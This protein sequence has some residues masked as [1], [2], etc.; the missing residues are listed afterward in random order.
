[1]NHYTDDELLADA[2][3]LDAAYAFADAF[4]QA[5][6]DALFAPIA[7]AEGE[8]A[9]EVVL[10]FYAGDGEDYESRG[11]LIVRRGRG[12]RV[13]TRPDGE[14]GPFTPGMRGQEN[15]DYLDSWL[16]EILCQECG[17]EVGV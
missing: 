12:V 14:R 8:E 10:T 17:V 16:G 7:L 11:F 15:P 3:A 6:Y 13:Y 1:M 2:E 4:A 9:R 5:A